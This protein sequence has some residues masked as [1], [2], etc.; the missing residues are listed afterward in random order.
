MRKLLS[1]LIFCGGILGAQAQTFTNGLINSGTTGAGA[2]VKLGGTLTANTTVDLTTFIF[3]FK[4]TALPNLFSITNNG[5]VGIG[6]LPTS[7]LHLSAGTATANTAPLKFTTG[8]LLTT[9]EAGAME[10]SATG[11]SFS[12]AN[13]TR[14]IMAYADLSN[15]S[16]IL[17][18]VNGGT[19]FAGPVVAGDLL[20]ATSATAFTKRAIG[21]TNQVLTV[22]GG[23]PTW[24]TPTGG[25]GTVTSFAFTNANGF[26]GAVATGTTIPTL[27][28]STTLNG[29][30]RGNGTGFTTGQANLATEVTGILPIL[31]GGT[32]ATT[33]AAAL[34]AI[35]PAQTGNANK[36][37]RTDGTTAT[38]QT[39]SGTGTVTTASVVTANGISGT[40]ATAT[41]TPAITLSLG[42]ITPASVAAT[43]TLA[44]SN[45]SGTN[46]GDNAPNTLYSGLVTNAT[47]TG[48]VT[49]AT[50]LTLATVNSNVGSFT[51]ANIT[52]NAKGLITAASNG[53][54]SNNWSLLGNAATVP[55]TNFIGTTDLQRL[56][57]KTNNTERAT[58]LDNGNIGIGVLNPTSTLNI[59]SNQPSNSLHPFRAGLIL[60]GDAGTIGGRMAL[61][62]AGVGDPAEPYY[63][64][65]RSNGTLAAPTAVL[66]NEGLNNFSAAGHTGTGWSNG[67]IGIIKIKADENFSSVANGTSIS[68]GT[69]LNGTTYS[70]ERMIIK[71]NGNVGIGT[72]TPLS[73]LQ[74]A[75]DATIK[76]ALYLDYSDVALYPDGENWINFHHSRQNPRGQFFSGLSYNNAGGG[77]ALRSPAST[78]FTYGSTFRISSG[79][80]NG[81]GYDY[82]RRLTVNNAGNVGIGTETPTAILDVQ[83][84]IN[85][86]AF[87]RMTTVQKLA[88]VAP[89][90]GLEVY[91]LTLKQ[92]SFYN[93]IAWVQSASAGAGGGTAWL[94]GGNT[95]TTASNFIGTTDAQDLVF[96]TNGQQI[97]K[98][99]GDGNYTISLGAGSDASGN[100][101]IAIGQDVTASGSS[102][103]AFGGSTMASGNG[104]TA[105]GYGAS[106]SGE[107]STAMG[108]GTTAPSFIETGIGSYN[109]FYT[110]ASTTAWVV[111]D[112]LLSIGNGIDYLNRSDAFTILKNG[113]TGIGTSTPTE[114]LDVMGS[115]Y[116]NDK[117][118][119][120]TR[121]D[122]TALNPALTPAQLGGGHK[123]FVNGSAIFTKAVVRLTSTWPDYVFEPTNKLP[124]LADVEAYINKYKHLEGVPSAAEVKEK[125]IDLGDNQTILLKKV[126][127][128]TLYMIE[129][130][131]KVEALAK[132]NE[133]LKKKVNGDK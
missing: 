75:G 93:G 31:N 120:G 4:T 61:K 14:K 128:L 19:G 10:F 56:V 113:K 27:T 64:S 104:S 3:G 91:D 72:T 97:A 54:A 83:S 34:T 49:G 105:M 107:F 43:G 21:A 125:G 112:R 78:D 94:T 59:V 114:K 16:G 108:A 15:L 87:P 95:G 1:L 20:Y 101:S 92:K 77:V 17:P 80:W 11:L 46:T 55:G 60:E 69:T 116:A 109:T 39:V 24:A 18:I 81:T 132:E 28:L 66:V 103:V 131:K 30:L 74:V 99:S 37:L 9:A 12:P 129:L 48:D 102:S 13:G 119:I 35:L 88:I 7:L 130:N 84:T 118:F 44:G 40:V 25:T 98:F 42:A 76:G 90:E 110:P 22:V 8:T 57:F 68:F 47:H 85:G 100:A 111:T 41:T 106:A 53:A 124:S 58:I 122:G 89:V 79:L 29:L 115:V 45:L 133:E 117:I 32:G 5:K 38:W 52:V 82:T 71:N 26:I 123:L 127:E 70:L 50:A 36:V 73:K 62:S 96:K 6:I 126:E 63:F 86:V 65:Y 67:T 33:A 121:G 2:V 23:V 51:N